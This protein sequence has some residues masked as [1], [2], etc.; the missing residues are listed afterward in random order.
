M[1]A[2]AIP[3]FRPVDNLDQALSVAA[4]RSEGIAAS[5][6][7]SIFAG[8]GTVGSTLGFAGTAAGCVALTGRISVAWFAAGGFIR[9][10]SGGGIVDVRILAGGFSCGLAAS[11]GGLAGA[12]AAAEAGGGPSTITGRSGSDPEG[13]IW[14]SDA[15]DIPGNGCAN[16][17]RGAAKPC[18]VTGKAFVT[19]SG[20]ANSGSGSG[21]GTGSTSAA[22]FGASSAAAGTAGSRTGGFGVSTCASE[23]CG[24]E[25]II[26]T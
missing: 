13:G 25:S 9:T 14:T 18:S 23:S 11:R 16:F 15:G 7:G 17:P 19:N 6:A 12:G 26:S 24:R 3:I 2:A 5:E 22:A 20:G 1:A 4:T 10:V 21:V 8:A